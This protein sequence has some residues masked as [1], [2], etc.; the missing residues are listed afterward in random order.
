VIVA[1][2]RPP[3]TSEIAQVV[4]ISPY[5]PEIPPSAHRAGGGGGGGDRSPTP[6][7][8]GTLPRFAREQ[9]TPPEAKILNPQPKLPMAPTLIGLPNSSSLRWCPTPCSVTPPPS[10]DRPRTAPVRLVGS[11]LAAG[12]GVGSG[13]GAGV[14]PGEGGVCE[15]GGNVIA[16]IPIYQPVEVHFRLFWD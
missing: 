14:G 12:G 9:F 4:E 8:Q 1:S 2:L 5:L 6:A 10:W 16:P 7:S 11:A 3:K 13:S 15:A